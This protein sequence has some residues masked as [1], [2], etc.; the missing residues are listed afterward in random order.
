M[1]TRSAR[2]RRDDTVPRWVVT[3]QA[4]W[5]GA[6]AALMVR[7]GRLTGAVCLAH[8]RPETWPE[9]VPVLVT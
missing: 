5:C 3:R 2:R 8:A 9:H 6:P 4:C 7:V 1:A